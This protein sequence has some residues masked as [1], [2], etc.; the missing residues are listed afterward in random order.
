MRGLLG[1]F[2]SGTGYQ[3][4]TAPLR[5]LSMP[6]VLRKFMQTHGLS[7]KILKGNVF[8]EPFYFTTLPYYRLFSVPLYL[9]IA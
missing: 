2:K 4:Q 8:W 9:Y 1:F 5:C 6:H 3:E 7:P